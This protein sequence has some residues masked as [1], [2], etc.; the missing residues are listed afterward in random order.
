MMW[1]RIYPGRL[2]QI[3]QVRSWVRAQ[4]ADT[5]RADD[6]ALIAAELTSNALLHT[7]SGH[8]GG[9]F[10]V[11]L[12]RHHDLCLAVHDLGGRTIPAF[13]TAD[14]QG[15]LAE[16]GRG[17]RVVAELAAQVGVEGDPVGGHTVWAR[18]TADTSV[19]CTS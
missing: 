5:E 18:L 13:S 10:G 4:C 8:P 6:A 19:P 9:W 7:R 16:H 3:A 12:T 1:R 11:E 15:V 14:G 17:L 2:D